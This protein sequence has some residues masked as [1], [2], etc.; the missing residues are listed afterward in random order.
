M[1]TPKPSA[2]PIRPKVAASVTAGTI[3]SAVVGLL[4]AVGVDVPADVADE[5]VVGI[6][7][8]TTVVTFV[9]GYLKRDPADPRTPT[10]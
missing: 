9:A 10:I 6:A 4:V 7:A 5:A 1:T 8:L 2:N 3:A